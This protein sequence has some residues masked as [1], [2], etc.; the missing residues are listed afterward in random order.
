MATLVDTYAMEPIWTT[1]KTE[2]REVGGKPTK[3][4]YSIDGRRAKANDPATWMSYFDAQQCMT[5]YGHGG[6]NFMLGKVP[7][8]DAHIGG[9]DLD[10]CISDGDCE[11][12]AM[13]VVDAVD[14]YTE[15]SPSGT[16][17]RIFFTYQPELADQRWRH[18]VQEPKAEGRPKER[19]IEFYLK[20]HALSVTGTIFRAYSAV[21]EIGAEVME[22]V[23]GLMAKFEARYKPEPKANGHAHRDPPPYRIRMDEL[24]RLIDAINHISSSGLPWFDWN[25]IGMAIWASTSGS[26]RGYEA[27]VAFSRNDP[28]FSERNCRERW[29]NWRRSPPDRLSEGT[30]FHHAQEAGWKDPNTGLKR[31]KPK[32]DGRASHEP[33]NAHG[34]PTGDAKAKPF[35]TQSIHDVMEEDVVDPLD[36]VEGLIGSGNYLTLVYGPSTAG[37][38]FLM[39]S[40]C[41]AI[42]C[43]LP[44]FG[45]KTKRSGVLYIALEGEVGFKNRLRA[46]AMKVLAKS[47]ELLDLPFRFITTPVNFGPDV[48]DVHVL[49]VIATIEEMNRQFGD[50]AAVRMLVF[51]NLRAIAVGMREG[52]SEEVAMVFEKARKVARAAGAAPLII[53]NTGKDIDRGARGSQAQFDLADAVIEVTGDSTGRQFSA[54]KVRDGETF[55]PIGYRLERVELGTVK[56]IDGED[57]LITSTVVV[58]DDVPRP[59]AAKLTKAQHAYN[60]LCNTIA[61]A[62]VELPR[63]DGF[64][65]RWGI[66]ATTRDAFLHELQRAGILATPEADNLDDRALKSAQSAVRAR[67]SEITTELVRKT[68]IGMRDKYLWP[69]SALRTD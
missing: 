15:V 36:L 58:A 49:K 32:P 26:Q 23:Q 12:W 29:E 21:R 48:D 24:D 44:W 31:E 50:D 42:V 46:Y 66:R 41:M 65:D 18:H 56:D 59:K 13:E 38:T 37:K 25:T 64:P 51:D 57:K 10:A 43:G 28:D 7:D 8:T 68:Q 5:K 35:D 17:L 2:A 14:S 69:T 61:K 52:Y 1:W 16:G 11:P 30:I 27:F 60:V 47:V 62:S 67:F 45:R 63:G 39:I 34:E 4:P 6:I 19:G 40:L 55:G 54:M 20:N 3:V 22:R 53:Q 33:V 9:V